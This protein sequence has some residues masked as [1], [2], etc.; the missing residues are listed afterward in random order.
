MDRRELIVLLGAAAVGAPS[1]VDIESYRPRFFAPDEYELVDALTAALIP[2]DGTPGAR[3]AGVK[4]FIDTVLFHGDGGMQAMWRDGLA[5]VERDAARTAGRKF[6]KCSPEEQMVVMD[7]FEEAG[8]FRPFKIL[9]VEAFAL[10]DAGRKFF[11]YEGNTAIDEFP[12]C[13]EKA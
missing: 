6:A 10:S 3:E 1:K 11:G 9:T 13:Q 12:G 2:S 4:Y 7:R 5:A 8:F